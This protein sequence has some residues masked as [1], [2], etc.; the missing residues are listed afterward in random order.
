MRLS[1]EPRRRDEHGL[2]EDTRRLSRVAREN[3]PHAGA[4]EAMSAA[5]AG[6]LAGAVL[7]WWLGDV[8]WWAFGLATMFVVL[9]VAKLAP[10]VAFAFRKRRRALRRGSGGGS[11][12]GGASYDQTRSEG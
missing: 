9:P 6:A 4:I 2:I 3:V 10:I 12:P 5:V 1:I 7:Q 8:S 11:D